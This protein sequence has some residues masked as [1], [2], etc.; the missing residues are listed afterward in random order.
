MADVHRRKEYKEKLPADSEPGDITDPG[1]QKILMTFTGETP[2][3][4]ILTLE[5]DR[6]FKSVYKEGMTAEN[7]DLS[8]RDNVLADLSVD[9]VTLKFSEQKHIFTEL[10]V[11]LAGGTES[12]LN[13][14]VAVLRSLPRL[15]DALYVNRLSKF[16]RGLALF[17]NRD[18]IEGTISGFER[19]IEVRE[20]SEDSDSENETDFTV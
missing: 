19:R 7:A 18:K 6:F 8:L 15:C 12:D 20:T 5:Q 11:E 2:L 13:D 1:I 16:E 3:V 17:F 9:A 14:F 4:P 10:E